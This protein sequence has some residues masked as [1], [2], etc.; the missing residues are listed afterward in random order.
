MVEELSP[1]DIKSAT[2][3][4]EV[5]LPGVSNSTS[6]DDLGDLHS[7]YIKGWSLLLIILA[8]LSPTYMYALIK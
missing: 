4:K 6:A 5:P 3:S 2:P 7:K 8:W 1:A